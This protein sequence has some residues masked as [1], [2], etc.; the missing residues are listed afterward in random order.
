MDC[1]SIASTSV[2][3]PWSTCAMMAML[4][5]S[6]RSSVGKSS[7]ALGVAAEAAAGAGG[8]SATA[9]VETKRRAVAVARFLIDLFSKDVS[10]PAV[11]SSGFD[12]R[13]L[14]TKTKQG[15]SVG[16]ELQKKKSG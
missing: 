9:Q 16:G 5:M 1:L 2:V 4:R 6:S 10:S 15:R 12:F 11:S 13:A 14:N 8:A 3:L 7:A